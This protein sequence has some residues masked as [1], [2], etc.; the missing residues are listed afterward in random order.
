METFIISAF[1]TFFSMCLIMLLPRMKL[2]YDLKV[3]ER[4]KEH[5][6]EWIRV[7]NNIALKRAEVFLS[8]EEKET[9]IHVEKWVKNYN[10]EIT[11]ITRSGRSLLTVER[12]ELRFL[13]NPNGMMKKG[14]IADWCNFYPEQK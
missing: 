12:G 9:F 6:R 5:E 2:R 8:K 3:I 13:F 11:R 4:H 1:I 7:S 14:F 10:R